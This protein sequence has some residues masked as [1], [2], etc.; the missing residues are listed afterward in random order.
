M[1]SPEDNYAGVLSIIRSINLGEPIEEINSMDKVELINSV[2]NTNTIETIS[3]KTIDS[4][5]TFIKSFTKIELQ[6]VL[7]QLK[8]DFEI[9][10]AKRKLVQKIVNY[11]VRLLVRICFD[12][13]TQDKKHAVFQSL[14]VVVPGTKKYVNGNYYKG[15]VSKYNQSET[16]CGK[17]EKENIEKKLHYQSCYFYFFLKSKGISPN[18]VQMMYAIKH[19]QKK[20]FISYYLAVNNREMDKNALNSGDKE[21][22][23]SIPKV[24]RALQVGDGNIVRVNL[25][26]HQ[27][28]IMKASRS[29]GLQKQKIITE[30]MLTKFPLSLGKIEFVDEGKKYDKKHAEEFLCDKA[31]QLKKKGN[32]TFYIYGKRRPCITCAA[33]MKV[34]GIHHYNE[35]HGRLFRHTTEHLTDAQAH[36]VIRILVEEPS[37]ITQRTVI[38]KQKLEN[39]TTT[40]YASDTDDEK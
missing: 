32:Y 34:T 24:K 9:G 25:N 37:Y 7:K 19:T 28:G 5:E 38:K 2:D 4:E 35:K 31:D 21:G 12:K 1:A 17:R 23:N 27:E 8:I 11:L 29:G 16:P 36:E 13:L 14:T 10:D 33:R 3:G 30:A 40:H 18:E 39:I 26:E 22:K 6:S 20:S 15:Y